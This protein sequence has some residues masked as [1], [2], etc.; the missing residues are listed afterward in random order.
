MASHQKVSSYLASRSIVL[1]GLAASEGAGSCRDLPVPFTEPSP[2]SVL[3]FLTPLWCY[4]WNFLWSLL[5]A[6]DPVTKS[7][8]SSA[9]H[10]AWPHFSLAMGQQQP[11]EMNHDL[12]QGFTEMVVSRGRLGQPQ[13]P[14]CHL[15]ELQE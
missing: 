14:P 2:S 3:G 7:C 12:R 5:P 13:F 9:L 15:L 8:Q 11:W 10:I 4:H 1:G 6:E